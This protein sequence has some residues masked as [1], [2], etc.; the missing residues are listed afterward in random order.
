MDPSTSR[1]QPAKYAGSM[2]L[3]AIA[4]PLPRS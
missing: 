4:A 3:P 2:R 1:A